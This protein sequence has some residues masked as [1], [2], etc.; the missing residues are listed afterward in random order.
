MKGAGGVLGSNLTQDTF[1]NSHSGGGGGFQ[2]GS[3][4]YVSYIWSLVFSPG[5]CEIGEFGRMKFGRGNRSTK[6]KHVPVPLCPP[7]IPI[8]YTRARTRATA[9]GSQRLIA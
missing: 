5:G 7:Q 8:D 2:I 9:V 6:R 1:F 3:T 4:R